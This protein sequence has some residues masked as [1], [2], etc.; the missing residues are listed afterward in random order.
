MAT[1]EGGDD[2]NVV[3]KNSDNDDK[4]NLKVED[5]EE[6]KEEYDALKGSD[7]DVDRMNGDK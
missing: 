3:T 6:K 2:N 1:K 5:V 7:K 4:V